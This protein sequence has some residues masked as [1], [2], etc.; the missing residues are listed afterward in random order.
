MPPEEEE[1]GG[2][3]DPGIANMIGGIFSG[4]FQSAS[5]SQDFQQSQ[6]DSK[7]ADY[8]RKGAL[9]PE[10]NRDLL[11]FVGLVILLIFLVILFKFI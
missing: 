9:T 1:Q 5:Q 4:I 11:I 3:S 6:Y 7:Q 10:Q 2:G 8:F